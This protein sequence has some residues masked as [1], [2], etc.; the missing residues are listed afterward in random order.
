MLPFAVFFLRVLHYYLFTPG[1][2]I[3]PSLLGC[4]RVYIIITTVRWIVYFLHRSAE[5]VA[6]DM[7][8]G[9]D[10]FIADHIVLGASMVTILQLEMVFALD[11][12]FRHRTK[13][14]WRGFLTA[15]LDIT[16]L[17]IDI[18]LA[19]ILFGLTSMDMHYTARYFHPRF[20]SLAAFVIGLGFQL[21]GGMWLREQT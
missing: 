1:R 12:L 6:R 15:L 13:E 19:L 21:G 4:F 9:W 11:T 7:K 2:V 14:K 20:Q 17:V 10:H 18:A 16:L 8:L 5:S 3:R